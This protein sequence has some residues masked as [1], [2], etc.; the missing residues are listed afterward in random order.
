MY[1]KRLIDVISNAKNF[2]KTITEMSKN[3]GKSLVE[4]EICGIDFDALTAEYFEKYNCTHPSRS[5]D[6]I[7]DYNFQDYFVEF[8]DQ[9]KPNTNELREKIRN[10]LLVYLDKIDEK[11]SFARENLGYI[12]VYNPN[13]KNYYDRIRESVGKHTENRFGLKKDFEGLYFKEVICIPADKFKEKLMNNTI[14]I[15][16]KKW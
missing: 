13:K 14:I 12:L 4:S 6:S 10:S 1:K 5:N 15:S 11:V 9:E 16:I 8:K 2:I 3:Q 7:I